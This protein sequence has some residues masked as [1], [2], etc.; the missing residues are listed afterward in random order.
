MAKVNKCLNCKRG[1]YLGREKDK[2]WCNRWNAEFAVTNTCGFHTALSKEN[3]S[4]NIVDRI[5]E[6][7]KKFEELDKEL[8]EIKER[9]K[10]DT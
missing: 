4:D 1:T 7:L 5:D 2:M 3:V 8:K 6:V 10:D 9:L